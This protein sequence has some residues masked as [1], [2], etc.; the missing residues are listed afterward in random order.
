MSVSMTTAALDALRSAGWQVKITDRPGALPSE[1]LQRYPDLPSPVESFLAGLECC[2]SPDKTVWF[3]GPHEYDSS[4]GLDFR[5]NEWEVLS[6]DAASDD[7]EVE[8][9]C[10]F[11]DRHC[12]FL[13]S[14]GSGYAFLAVALDSGAVVSGMEPE[15]ES[16]SP[17]AA[18]FDQFLERLVAVLRDGD[19]T[20]HSLF[21]RSA[22]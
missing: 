3:L 17:V 16:T 4:S 2:V 10:S 9:I 13:L 14:V 11:W 12:P 22:A 21:L 18:S 20:L 1:V 6:L 15:F 7:A 8:Q 5:W 19:T